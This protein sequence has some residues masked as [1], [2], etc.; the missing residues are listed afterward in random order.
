MLA[1]LPAVVVVL[2]VL[3]LIFVT[4]LVGGARARYG[5][6]APATTGNENFERVFRMQ[7]NT[8][9]STVLFLPA[10]WLGTQ[11]GYPQIAG[12]AGLVWVA[13]RFWYAM[14][15]SEA[16]NKRG[17]AFMIASTAALVAFA[18]GCWG[19]LRALIG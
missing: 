19:L 2:T 15:Y 9:E 12:I 16:A 18:A 5:V 14:A 7:M 17:L 11:Y 10:L 8:V 13:A 1:H 4:W 6:K 3:L